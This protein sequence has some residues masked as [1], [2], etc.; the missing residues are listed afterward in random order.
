[1]GVQLKKLSEQV[2]VIT[3]ALF[4]GAGLPAEG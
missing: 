4:A 3:G 1:M 2:F